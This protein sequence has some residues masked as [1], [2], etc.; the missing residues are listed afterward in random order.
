MPVK[1]EDEAMFIVP[2]VVIVP[3]ERPSPVAIEVTDPLPLPLKV[4][5]SVLDKHPAWLPE[6]V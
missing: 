3:P 2:V 1:I 5:Q 6:A 4:F